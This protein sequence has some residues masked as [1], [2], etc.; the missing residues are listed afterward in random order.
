MNDKGH[1]VELAKDKLNSYPE[2][3]YCFPINVFSSS[4]VAGAFAGEAALSGRACFFLRTPRNGRGD[5]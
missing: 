3:G 2:R 1:A 4:E 5:R